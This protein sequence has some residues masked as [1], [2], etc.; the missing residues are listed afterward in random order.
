[1]SAADRS[2]DGSVPGQQPEDLLDSDGGPLMADNSWLNALFIPSCI[3]DMELSAYAFRVLCH[4]KRRADH[5]GKAFPGMRS[6]AKKCCLSV[7][8]V[9]RAV[10]ELQSRGVL[11]VQERGDNVS[12]LY[13][14]TNPDEWK[15]KDGKP[16]QHPNK[17]RSPKEGAVSIGNTPVSIANAPVSVGNSAVSIANSPVSAGNTPVPYRN[18]RVSKGRESKEGDPPKEIQKKEIQKETTTTPRACACATAEPPVA[19]APSS[20]FSSV[21]DVD[22]DPSGHLS[23]GDRAELDR[24][25]LEFGSDGRQRAKAEACAKSRGMAFVREQAD[26]VRTKPDVRNLAGAFE[27]ACDSPD[28]WKRPKAAAKKPARPKAAEPKPEEAPS[29]PQADFSAELAWWQSTT[30]AQ[31]EAILRDSRF[32]LY[33]KSMR[34]GVTAASLGL[35]V[36]REVLAAL[37]QGAS[38]AATVLERAQPPEA[39]AA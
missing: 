28:G 6:I 16:F 35:P 17:V 14:L 3:D 36:L 8:T 1:M 11:H 18:E 7:S 26:I 27:K 4:L 33:R 10:K 24:I 34:K 23:P 20:S 15:G 29:E 22:E 21:D 9:C 2:T 5:S 19:P 30:D 12:N 37:A 32:D 39:A 31:R 13:L 25:A 38:C